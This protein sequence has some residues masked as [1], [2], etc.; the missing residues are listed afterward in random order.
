MNVA[1]SASGAPIPD[2]VAA[3]LTEIAARVAAR[4]AEPKPTSAA[5]E[6]TTRNKALEVLAGYGPQTIPGEFG[7]VP[8]YAVVMTGRF[9]SPRTRPPRGNRPAPRP[10]IGSCLVIV[11]EA[12][13][14]ELRDVGVRDWHPEA[15][16]SRLGPV[17]LLTL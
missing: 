6:A 13:T 16:L 1:H 11:V 4:H 3:R 12:A 15:A 10:I 5:A 9:T 17:T 14:L 2:D 8:V 7:T